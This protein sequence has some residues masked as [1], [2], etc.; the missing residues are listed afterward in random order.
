MLTT[1][2]P[3]GLLGGMHFYFY[4]QCLHFTNLIKKLLKAIGAWPDDEKK[5]KKGSTKET[6][7]ESVAAPLDR[8]LDDD[9]VDLN[10]EEDVDDGED[11]M[12]E[13][14]REV[15]YWKVLS[16]VQK[17]RSQLIFV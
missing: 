9:A 12:T 6:Y 16:V 14:E 7:Q 5:K 3:S 8:E 10:E 13:E 2:L 17:V 4:L 11:E 15:A 1:Y